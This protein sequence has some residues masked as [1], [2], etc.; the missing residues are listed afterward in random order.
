VSER[1]TD[2]GGTFLDEPA[3]LNAMDLA[4]SSHKAT[5]GWQGTA[6]DSV[7][8]QLCNSGVT[9]ASKIAGGQ[10]QPPEVAREY[11]TLASLSLHEVEI[12]IDIS[13]HMGYFDK[14]TAE[15]LFLLRQ[16]VREPLDQL[17]EA[18]SREF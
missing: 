12:L 11:L 1:H 10:D 8:L 3:W 15:A 9:V 4:V 18:A 5:E 2:H 16:D 6:R 13:F 14:P 7:R 17:I